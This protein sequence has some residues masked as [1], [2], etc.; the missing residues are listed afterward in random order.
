MTKTKKKHDRCPRRQML[1]RIN[2]PWKIRAERKQFL[3]IAR[4]NS[5]CRCSASVAVSVPRSAQDPEDAGSIPLASVIF[6][7]RYLC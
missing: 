2:V 1:L 6:S 7:K 4:K 5:I 3:K